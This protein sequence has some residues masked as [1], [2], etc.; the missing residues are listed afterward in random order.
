MLVAPIVLVGNKTDSRN[1]EVRIHELAKRNQEH[2]KAEDGY[3]MAERI[4][5][6]AY[7]E[8]S[9]EWNEGVWEVFEN[10]AL[11]VIPKPVEV[12]MEMEMETEM[13]MEKKKS[14][15]CIVL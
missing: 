8:C 9:A 4:G 3:A 1:D 5:A 2:V 6:F 7:L 14:K 15:M 13:K 11:A 10:A 12:E